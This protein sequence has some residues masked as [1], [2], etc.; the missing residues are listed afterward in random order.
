LFWGSGVLRDRLKGSL[1]IFEGSNKNVVSRVEV[2]GH[3]VLIEEVLYL[4]VENI[5]QLPPVA[6][7]SFLNQQF[8]TTEE[9]KAL[10]KTC[11]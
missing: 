6:T 5:Q 11:R 2:H 10:S 3:K 8:M 4:I 1:G 9:M 7:R